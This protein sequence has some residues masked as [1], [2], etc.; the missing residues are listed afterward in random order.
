[1]STGTTRAFPALPV[2]GAPPR[3]RVLRPIH[4]RP[5]TGELALLIHPQSGAWVIV[6]AAHV[7]SVR[8]FLD[9]CESTDFEEPGL[10]QSPLFERLRTCGL[11]REQVT[12]TACQGACGG[13]QGQLNTL[14]L[15]MVG[16]CDLACT[17]CY[18]YRAP[19]YSHRMSE[20]VARRA[21]VDSLARCGPTLLILF[22]GG[23]PLLASD[24]I[25]SLV[26]FA[27]EAAAAAGRRVEFSIQTNGRHFSADTV[28]FLLEHRF[29]IGVSLDGRAD[30]NDRY[31]VDHA[32]RGRF[33]EI[34]AA[35]TA[36]PRL[37]AKVGVL[38]TVTRAN[39]ATL[40]DTA[41]YCRDL[42]I[43]WWDATLFQPLG[44]GAD[45]S[46]FAAETDV[47][48]RSYLEL[49][50]A[51]EAGE[52]DQMSVAPVLRY[53]RNVLS[54]ERRS[55]CLRDAC[56]AAR[57][58]VSVSVDGTIQSCD[59]IGD[60][61]LTLG[62]MDGEGIAAALDGPVAD[63]I[64]AR[65]TATL[66]PCQ[67]CDWRSFCGGTCLARSGLQRIDEVECQI[68]LTLFTEIFRRLAT[69]DR[70]ERYARLFP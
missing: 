9:E 62:R 34:E 14:I 27:I 69:S 33:G 40:L 31:R 11:I 18:D 49:F 16:Y 24:Q 61:A 54:S 20:D 57:D 17:Y 21:I 28:D 38:T 59:C 48:I 23:E 42:G 3:Y 65:S 67:D 36:N 50:D 58:L 25:R 41:C 13:S 6:R 45:A 10:D 15:K 43:R 52:F 30:V 39:A 29:T 22:H 1:M 55:M 8:A 68:A 51:V 12:G 4:E 26:P 7:D 56:G 37:L 70:L 53:L 47:V 32:G 2:L 44:R 64:R 19:I 66:S 63:T 46:Q 35:L 60:P 5:L